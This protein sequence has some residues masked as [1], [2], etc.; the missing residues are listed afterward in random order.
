MSRT[1]TALFDTKPDAEAGRDRL[2]AAKL[3]AD[4]VQIMDQSMAGEGKDYSTQDKPG[5]WASIKN[6]FLPDE[7]RHTYEEGVRRGGFLLTADVDEGEVDMAVRALEDTNGVDI[8]ERS[9]TWKS[10]GWDYQPPATTGRSAMAGSTNDGDRADPNA[11]GRDR[12]VDDGQLTI[13][14]RELDRGG[15][16][17]RSYVT[18]RP[19]RDRVGQS[20]ALSSSAGQVGITA[21]GMGNEALGNV[22]QGIGGVTGSDDI[23]RSGEARERSGELQ[24]DKD[25]NRY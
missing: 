11:A 23:E 13:G 15:S 25:T 16:R 5:M 19:M 18:D 12:T 8:E 7:D 22:Q 10:E 4:N 2:M 20:S 17:A 1:V 9:K 21:K 6:A 24:Q 14:R 3:D